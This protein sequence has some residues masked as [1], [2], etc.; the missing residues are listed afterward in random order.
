[1]PSLARL[2]GFSALLLALFLG[3]ALLAQRWLQ[4][5]HAVLE[6]EALAARRTQFLAAA[7]ITG[8][9]AAPWTDARLAAIG[10]MI[11]ATVAFAPASGRPDFDPRRELAFAVPLPVPDGTA[12]RVAAVRFHLPPTAR[13]SLLHGRTW[14][15]L[16]VLAL[17]L[18]LVFVS[19]GLAFTRGGR[20][21]DT[22][23][24]WAAARAEMGSLE[25]LARS[26]IAQ[27]SALAAA[28]DQQAK[29]EQDLSLNQRLLHRAVEEKVRIGR[30]LHDGLIQSLYAVGLTIE[31]ARRLTRT[32][33]ARADAKLEQCLELLNRTIR[34]V[35]NYITGLAPETL[36]RM[37]F[38]AAVEAQLRELA[39]GRDATLE[40]NIDDEAAAAL[41]PEQTIEALQVSR[42]AISNGLRH[43]AARAFVVR[44]HRSDR[45][46]GL[47]VQ[48]DGRGFDPGR[49]ARSG[50]GLGNMQARAADAGGTLR[51]DSRPG[52]GTRVVMTFPVE[53]AS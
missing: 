43:G 35:R 34:D 48:D 7:E 10:R 53:V 45:E 17:T 30:D 3:A 33:P 24:P 28:R 12:A 40:L 20:T 2:L 23:S 9:A 36:R 42:E 11:D 47:L 31:A 8:G 16:L 32:E 41:S 39:A 21:G 19:V 46:V 51:I 26:S 50:H 38:A 25:Q 44:L 52:E 49:V 5:Q 27:G 29:V 18:M 37:S 15:M 1:M 6:T 22:R 14:I 13:L 4:Q